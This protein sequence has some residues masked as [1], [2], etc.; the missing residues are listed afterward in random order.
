MALGLWVG[1]GICYIRSVRHDTEKY[2]LKAAKANHSIGR[3]PELPGASICLVGKN[4]APLTISRAIVRLLRAVIA[5]ISGECM[6]LILR[7]ARITLRKLRRSDALDMQKVI[8]HKDIAKWTIL[9]PYP[10]A[11]DEARRFISE[12]L[13][14]YS[15]KTA[16]PLAITLNET[17]KVIGLIGLNEINAGDKHAELGYWLGKQYWNRGIT[18]EAIG[19]ICNFAFKELK[20]HKVF[21]MTFEQ[22]AA[23]HKVLQK[24]G[25]KLE[26]KLREEYY[27]YRR[28][29]N[30]LYWGL[31]S[32]EFKR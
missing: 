23:S 28:W 21:A 30:M 18:T 24:N 14:H 15:K 9:I 22:N 1:G 29:H 17:G 27:I 11:L 2:G 7:G 32:K 5:G 20:L 31:L 4:N 10:Y 16:Y 26:G 8:N 25:F 13:Q 3:Y 19:L 12:C 6:D